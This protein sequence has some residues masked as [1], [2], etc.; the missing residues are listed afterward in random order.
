MLVRRA[1]PDRPC[2]PHQGAPLGAPG[3]HERPSE[4]ETLVRMQGNGAI[5][6]MHCIY[7]VSHT[8]LENRPYSP[9]HID[10]SLETQCQQVPLHVVV[11][12]AALLKHPPHKVNINSSYVFLCPHS[13][14]HLP[15]PE[16]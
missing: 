1:L 9:F 16:F 2:V 4:V 15:V 7:T 10:R 3:E 12:H 8:Q 11:T 14:S 5:S 13:P 6:L